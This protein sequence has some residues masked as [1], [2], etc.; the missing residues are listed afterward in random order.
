MKNEI[1][2]P[3]SLTFHQ[4]LSETASSLNG[5]SAEEAAHRLTKFGP[6][7]FPTHR[8][9]TILQIFLHQ[10]LN[11]L[12]YIL[13]A[14]SFVSILIG[15]ITDAFFIGLVLFANAVIGTIQE[16]GAEKSAQAL[17]EMTAAKA[18]VERNGEIFEVDT[19][20]LVP[21]DIV[22]LESGRKVPADLRL[23]SSLALE[24]DESL[25]TGES[26]PVVKS[27]ELIHPAETTLGDRKNMAFTGTLVTKGRAKGVVVATALKTELGK[28]ADSLIEGVSA[29]PP[30]LIRMEKFTKKIAVFLLIVTAAMALVML[31][32]GQY[33]H[34]VL[35]FSVALAVSA[36]PEGLPVALTVALAVASRRMA[37]R[38]VIVRRLPAVEALGS[39]TFV[40][41]DKTGT[42]TV[43]QLTIQKVA[44]PGLETASVTGSGLD[45]QG[46]V[47]AAKGENREPQRKLVSELVVSGILCNEAQLAQKSGRWVGIGDAVD[48]AFL[49]LA[50]KIDLKPETVRDK[51][52]LIDEIPFEPENQ[53]AATLHE[54]KIERLI[55]VKGALEKLL[56]MCAHMKSVDGNVALDPVAITNQADQMAE[57]GYRVLALAA[58]FS[59]AED[60]SL[61][62]QLKDL[63][64]LGLV[65]MIDPLRPEAAE[66]IASCKAAGIEVAMVTGDH[67]K[68]SLS[69]ARSLGLAE[70]MT[71]VVS[72]PQLRIARSPEE[73]EKLIESARVFARVEPQQKLE[74]VQHL[75]AHGRFVAVTGDGANDAPALK[76][77]NVGVAMGKSGTDVAKETADLIITDD[78]FSSIVAGIEEGRIAYANVRKVVYLLI[79]T[80]AAEILMFGLSIAFGI[81][82]P[83]TAVQILWLNLVTNG[84]QD[85]GLAFEP[86]EGDELSLPPRKPHEPVFNRLML[87]RVIL[88][89]IVMGGVSFWYFDSLLKSG[90]S[91]DSARNATL[92]LMVFFENVMVGNCRSETKSAFRLNP[93]RNPVLLIGTIAAQVIHIAAMYTPGL[94]QVLGVGP[95]DL[96]E[97]LRLFAMALSVLFVM[98]VYKFVRAKTTSTLVSGSSEDFG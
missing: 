51:A 72:G 29:K 27:H 75:L 68:T 26:I 1:S 59:K 30:L 65:G 39:C 48:L 12:I 45:P 3:Y 49:V 84:I 77:A 98:E 19:G 16:Y 23:I 15:D 58:S 43:N 63:T 54:F 53:Y 86:G 97:W 85:V 34:D 73:K 41:T 90:V 13:V 11:P 67:P 83:L 70:R 60:L 93:F 21:G 14:A 69:I 95:V 80:G 82:L 36:I 62:A 76:A 35:M 94:R 81:P 91:L 57:Q 40:A 2:P 55:S 89:A 25:L 8:A 18:M 31:S 6:N 66:A 61:A 44:L 46:E 37:K 74:I 78:R 7:V 32:K 87:E 5:L 9:P 79:S 38:N 64:F 17:R 42:L 88:S 33:W 22:L 50:H 71:E 28:I 96:F 47:E 20:T 10:F 52:R 92:L 24:V 4:V 56:P